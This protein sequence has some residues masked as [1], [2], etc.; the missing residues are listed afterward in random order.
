MSAYGFHPMDKTTELIV[1][2]S[3]YHLR[4]IEDQY[5]IKGDFNSNVASNLMVTFQICDPDNPENTGATKCK[6]K[7]KIDEALTASYILLIENVERYK[8]QNSPTSG[9]MFKRE[10]T[11]SWYALSLSIRV[12]FLKKIIVREVK[13]NYSNLGLGFSG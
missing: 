13:Y 10:T 8:H 2:E 9:K 3:S 4:C 5:D 12:D 1:N 11:I 7:E 6:S